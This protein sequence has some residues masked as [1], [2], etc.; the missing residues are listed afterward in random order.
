MALAHVI[1]SKVEAA[2]R[3]GELLKKRRQLAEAWANI[4]HQPAGGE[5]EGRQDRGATTAGVMV[6]VFDIPKLQQWIEEIERREPAETAAVWREY[7][8]R[9]TEA[10]K[11]PHQ[12]SSLA[13][14][15]QQ[16]DVPIKD[17][18]EV[19]ICPVRAAADRSARRPPSALAA[20][21]LSRSLA[22]RADT[23][24][25]Y[26]AQQGR[27]DH[28]LAQEDG[29]R[30]GKHRSIPRSARATTRVSRRCCADRSA[31]VCES[32]ATATRKRPYL[33]AGYRNHACSYCSDRGRASPRSIDR[34]CTM[35]VVLRANQIYSR[36]GKPGKLPTG[37]SH[38]YEKI[39]PKLEKAKLGPKTVVYTERS[40]DKLIEEGIAEAAAERLKE[41]REQD[42]IPWEWIV[43]ETRAIE[44][45][46]D[47]GQSRRLRSLRRAILSPRFLESAAASGPSLEREGHRARRARPGARRYAV[48]FI[49]V[50]GFS[51]AT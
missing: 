8:K 29:T 35:L 48:G 19:L 6:R 45:V 41:A 10:W 42:I 43:D 22:G 1:D 30:R 38:F 5:A 33:E 27:M 17:V 31:G 39:A 23:A 47:L 3:R 46:V 24:Y 7:E 15:I 34:S 28:L 32:V 36:P 9:L 40:L 51:S 13:V 2:Y 26:R 16:P 50:H 49:P 44:R 12:W 4:L 20:P 11:K 37:K 18:A 25:R 14:L 21:A